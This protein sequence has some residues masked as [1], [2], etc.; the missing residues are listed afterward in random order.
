MKKIISIAFLVGIVCT[1]HAQPQ[2]RMNEATRQANSKFLL[3]NV[4]PPAKCP[5]HNR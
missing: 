3:D 1:T 5:I 2:P 4:A